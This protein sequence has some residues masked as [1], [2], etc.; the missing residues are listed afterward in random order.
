VELLRAELGR[1]E[2]WA[3]GQLRDF[4]KLAGTYLPV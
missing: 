1:D 4:D 3:V 2:A